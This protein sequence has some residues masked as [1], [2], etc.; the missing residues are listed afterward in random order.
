VALLTGVAA[1]VTVQVRANRELTAKNAELAEQQKEVEARFQ[2]AQ[3]AIATFHTGVSEDFLL[4][5]AEFKELRTK[6]LKEAASFY[7][8][9]E[10]LLAG[11]TD[12]KSR[13]L[14]ADGY[15]QLGELTDKIGD[16][17]EALAVHRKALA[18]RRELAAAE[19][20]DVET[21]L[22]VARSLEKVGLLLSMT[23]DNAGALAARSPDGATVRRSW[24]N[25][26]H[27]GVVR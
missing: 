8:D 24:H 26:R 15:F 14:L 12:P 9:L 17:K 10:K 11:K 25:A 6:L 22:D 7:S 21:R 16:K 23:G 2:M 13:K 3:K 19:G 5:N 1:V 4:K 20:A 27:D 18:L